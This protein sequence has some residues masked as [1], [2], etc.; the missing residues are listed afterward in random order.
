LYILGISAYFH[1]ASAAIFKDGDLIAAIEEEKLSR[2]KHDYGFPKHAIQYCLDEAKIESS[3][4]DFVVFYEKPFIKFERI[5]KT[6]IWGFPKTFK[7]F[8]ESMKGWLFDKLWITTT[9]Q[10]EL[11]I[12]RN[13][14]MFSNHHLSHAASSY[15]CSPFDKSA[16][17]TFDGVGEWA[18]T[19]ISEGNGSNITMKKEIRFPHS[20]GLIYSVFTAFLGFEINEGEYKVMGMAPYG[21]PVYTDKVRKVISVNNDGSF[22]VNKNY[23]SYHYSTKSSYSNE[24]V[25]L[26]GEPRESDKL[27]FTNKTGYPEYFGDKPNDYEKQV[28]SNQYYADIAASIQKVTE[29]IVINLLNQIPA[30]DYDYNLCLAGGVALNSVINGKIKSKTDFKNIYIQPSAGD[31]GGAIGAALTF[32]IDGQ[33]NKKSFVMK[34]AYWGPEFSNEDIKNAID[35]YKFKYIYFEDKNK[36]QDEIVKDLVNNKVIGLFQNR[37]EWGPRALGNRSIIANPTN[38]EMKDIVNAKIKFREPYRPFAPSVL[39]DKIST[40]FEESENE[41]VNNNDFMLNVVKVKKEYIP[42]IPAVSHM[43]TARVQAVRKSNTDYYNLIKKFEN[44]TKIPLLLNTSFNVKG[45]PIVCSPED[46]LNTFTISG[47]DK[48]ALGNYYLSKE[49]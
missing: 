45:E 9:I 46:A 26:F 29:E 48:L 8:Q 34:H 18:T 38:P 10:T 22:S 42:K 6:V 35:K 27:F 17:V 24:F 44:K 40:I 3:D 23:I 19:T 32:I 31:G 7:L 36:M 12:P 11:N 16:I 20:L 43:G 4:I 49:S 13:K 14:I 33:K 41:E 15:Y 39:E 1:D 2:I 30:K 28:E 25:K 47:L 5:L 21:N 37:I